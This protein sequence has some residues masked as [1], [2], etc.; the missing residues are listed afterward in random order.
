MN[1]L[2]GHVAIVTGGAMGIGAEIAAELARQGAKVAITDISPDKA[3]DI[4][5]KIQEEGGTAAAYFHDVTN[6]ESS[7]SMAD[8]V[9]AS[10]GPISVLVNNAGV[11]KRVPVLD[12]DEYEWDRVMDINLK[13]TFFTIK[14]VLPFMLD[15]GYG[16]I[17]NMSS[18]VGKKGYP[19]FSHYCAS[20][21]AV[22]GL[23]QSLASE[24]AKTGV[25][26]NSVC[27][28]IV[29]TPLHDQI[30]AEMA[31]AQGISFQAALTN[32]LSNV[33]QGRAQTPADIARIVTFLAAKESG[34]M[35]GGS[36]HVD[37]GMVMS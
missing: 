25:T 9:E 4:I 15:R 18:V 27:P 28:G 33:P 31:E 34:S 1:T 24:L 6:A 19:E 8:E 22:L 12:M 17:I 13:G 11:S 35:T 36:Y 14:A 30:V 7:L 5:S 16:R 2:K 23:S 3:K 32:F 20:K 26:V 37:G 29:M 10:L 21:F